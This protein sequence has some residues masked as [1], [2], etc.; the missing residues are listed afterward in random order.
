MEFAPSSLNIKFIYYIT[1]L[2][3]KFDVISEVNFTIKRD[4]EKAGL[5]FAY[6]TQ[7]VFVEK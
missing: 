6:P 2:P 3:R 7:T 5:D 4:F 1:D